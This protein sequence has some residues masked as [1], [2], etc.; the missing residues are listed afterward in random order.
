MRL[1]DS[2]SLLYHHHHWRMI[3][4]SFI[5]RPGAQLQFGSRSLSA[6]QQLLF[7]STKMR[8]GLW[9]DSVICQQDEGEQRRKRVERAERSG[10]KKRWREY[11]WLVGDSAETEKSVPLGGFHV[12]SLQRKVGQKVPHISG[13]NGNKS[14]FLNKGADK[15]S[16]ESKKSEDVI[17]GSP[18][19][20]F[21]VANSFSLNPLGVISP[22]LSSLSPPSAQ[23]K[24]KGRAIAGHWTD[25]AAF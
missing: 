25:G 15:G 3:D 2:L 16:Q 4:F 8:N 1:C 11:E 21:T 6:V 18:L 20:P 13:F 19:T 5:Y 14:I 7:S 9:C 23:K 17:Y 12:W 10:R 22:L 24:L